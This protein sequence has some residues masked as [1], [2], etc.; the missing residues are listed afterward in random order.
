MYRNSLH[1]Q[2]RHTEEG[3]QVEE[4]DNVVVEEVQHM[5]ESVG[6]RLKGSVYKTANLSRVYKRVCRRV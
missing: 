5:A 3:R 1:E 6:K 2:G 4:V